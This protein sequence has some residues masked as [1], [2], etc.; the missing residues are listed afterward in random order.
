MGIWVPHDASHEWETACGGD[1]PLSVGGGDDGGRD[2]EAARRQELGQHAQA[3]WKH[4][5]VKRSF[6]Q[7]GKGLEVLY[8]VSRG[9]RGQT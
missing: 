1:F 8:Q 9:D 2:K 5:C 6:H 7:L 3:Q 4:Y